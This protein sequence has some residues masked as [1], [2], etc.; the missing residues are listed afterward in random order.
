MSVNSFDIL[1]GTPL[2]A[3]TTLRHTIGEG[4]LWTANAG[5][6][7]IS[8]SKYIRKEMANKALQR[9]LDIALERQNARKEYAVILQSL[10]KSRIASNLNQIAYAVNTGTLVFSPDVIAQINETHEM[11]LYIRSLLI[12]ALGVRA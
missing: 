8:T 2:D 9:R 7:G 6:L 10:G 5:I 3:T 11:H 1:L 4:E 12:N